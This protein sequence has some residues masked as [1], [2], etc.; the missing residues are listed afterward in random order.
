[1]VQAAPLVKDLTVPDPGGWGGSGK[2]DGAKGVCS[3]LPV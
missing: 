1:M 3:H 2:E